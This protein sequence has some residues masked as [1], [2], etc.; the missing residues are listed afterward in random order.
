MVK[1][2]DNENRTYFILFYLFFIFREELI[3]RDL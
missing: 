2:F 1:R 3:S